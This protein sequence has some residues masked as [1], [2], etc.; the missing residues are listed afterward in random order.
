MA[1]VFLVPATAFADAPAVSAGAAATLASA[2]AEGPGAL[3]TVLRVLLLA[4]AT[5]TAGLGV[6]RLLPGVDPRPARSE[7]VVAWTAAGVVAVAAEV[8]YF[9]SDVAVPGTVVQV[10][11]ALAVPTLLGT[12][13][14]AL[15]ALPL[16]F[17]L[18]VQLASGRAGWALVLDAGYAL[19]ASLLAGIVLH[20]LT[21]ARGAR[22]GTGAGIIAGG[23]AVVTGTGQILVSGPY[24]GHELIRTGYGFAALA[25]VVLPALGTLAW[26]VA[27]RPR[28]GRH[29]VPARARELHR[30]AAVGAITGVVA[31]AL[32]AL[33]VPAPD[34]LAGRPLLRAVEVDGERLP[35]F[36]TPMRPGRNLVH[37]GGTGYPEAGQEPAA[38]SPEQRGGHGGGHHDAP[39]ARPTSVLVGGVATPVTS[40]PGAGGGWAVV[41]IDEG[42]D[43]LTIAAGLGE[44]TVPIDVGAGQAAE[45]GTIAG[46]D[47]PECVA[48]A[49]GALLVDGT[50]PACPSEALAPTEAEALRAT[51]HQL[52]AHGVT[53]A[54]LV[55]DDSAR[56]RAAERIVRETAGAEGIALPAEPDGLSALIVVSGWE[57]ARTTLT[58]ASLRARDTATFLGG[59]YLAPWL[60]TGG[61][62]TATSSSILPLAFSPQE[63]GPQRYAGLL[64][65][66]FPG[67]APSTAGY[68]A[69]AGAAGV[70]VDDRVT[71]FGAAPVD[72]PMT[73]DAPGDP[74][75]SSHHGGGNPAAWFPGGTVVPVSAP[76]DPL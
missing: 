41:D 16:A 67:E 31:A 48:A 58:E 61:V 43:T 56:S 25:A 70:A 62:V 59:T 63:P 55:A 29:D 65:R 38:A 5:V 57:T 28:R 8:S 1:G 52:G 76:L 4:A 33:P 15:P 66:T 32:A 11:L 3:V 74:A 69:W 40:R 37:L 34:V 60:L 19:A 42:T 23:I 26:T 39:T 7:Q 75:G 9:V 14:A 36:V 68:L 45:P 54:R 49:L 21:S 46:P 47:G 24:S 35:L 44:A 6:V 51:V 50:V 71:L 17:L 2:L 10:V 53:S 72:V 27:S 30:F 73:V 22:A 18:A 20:R 12:R 13:W 64:A